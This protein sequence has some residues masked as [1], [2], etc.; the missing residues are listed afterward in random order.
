MDGCNCILMFNLGSWPRISSTEGLCCVV[1]DGMMRMSLFRT[2]P[3]HIYIMM[4]ESKI[5]SQ[6]LMD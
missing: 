4:C 1:W 6:Y 2:V 5:R 3:A